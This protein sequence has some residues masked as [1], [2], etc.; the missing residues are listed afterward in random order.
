M[1]LSASR[2]TDLPAFYTEWFYRRLREGYALARGPFRPHRLSR[3]PLSAE[4]LDGVVFWS[5]NPAP[6]LEG[7][8]RAALDL[9]ESWG[10]PYYVQFTITPYGPEMEPGLPPKAG[11]L[12]LFRRLVRE[13]GPGRAVWRYDPVVVNAAC[14][15]AWHRERFAWMAEELAGAADECV[16]SFL[17]LYPRARSRSAGLA[18]RAVPPPVQRE[19][20]LSFAETAAKT[21]LRLR[22]C[23]E[24]PIREAAGILPGACIDP[25]RLER[26]G[27]FSLRTK[28]DA[29]QRPGCGCAESVDIG[30]YA[31]CPHG[32]VYCYANASVKT[33]AGNHARHDP[34]SPLLLGRPGDEDVIVPRRAAS[35]RTGQLRLF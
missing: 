12:A 28:R 33:A 5:K 13:R 19:L 24:E 18:D 1:I 26:L 25:C 21:G 7:P 31:T 6:L 30:A 32:C 23:C 35:A 9:L 34:A 4:V 3:V 22:S 11:L 29:G 8:G 10:V 2:R 14:T 15:A 20:A 27:G 17:D 16:F